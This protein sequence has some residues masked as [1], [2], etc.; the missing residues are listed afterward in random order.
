MPGLRPKGAPLRWLWCD[1][2]SPKSPN[3]R[4]FGRLVPILKARMRRPRPAKR[5]HRGFFAVLCLISW[6]LVSAFSSLAWAKP[7][8]E[9]QV[10][11]AIKKADPRVV[12]AQAQIDLAGAKAELATPR[13]RPQ[14]YYTLEYFDGNH[15]KEQ[16]HEVGAG[17][18]FVA[19]SQRAGQAQAKVQQELARYQ[20]ARTIHRRV[21]I[22][23]RRFYRIV[24]LQERLKILKLWKQG[25]TELVRIAQ[26]RVQAGQAPEYEKLR[27]ELALR[28]AESEIRVTQARQSTEERTFADYLGLPP[29]ATTFEGGLLPDAGPLKAKLNRSEE[30][31]SIASLVKARQQAEQSAKTMRHAWIPSLSLNAGLRMRREP[32]HQDWGFGVGITGSFPHPKRVTAVQHAAKAGQSAMQA[33]MQSARFD[34][35]Q[36]AQRSGLLCLALLEERARYIKEIR[37]VL[38]PL[39]TALKAEYREGQRDVIGLM[40]VL[41]RSMQSRRYR[42]DLALQARAAQLDYREATGE[43]EP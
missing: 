43:Y 13:W 9:T 4:G 34:A 42:L 20:A 23:L 38:L 2:K 5:V 7:L 25:L 30:R 36:A 6:I 41:E 37:A 15:G 26:A 35:Q 14:A 19:P 18:T 28:A 33:Q 16:E 39:E 32:L 1:A 21:M 3:I 24:A 8:G 29:G 11:A 31:R 12:Q 17:A 27:I 10:V 40:S 22:G